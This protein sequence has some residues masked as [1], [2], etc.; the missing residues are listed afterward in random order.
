MTEA[1][2]WLWLSFVLG[3]GAPHCRRLLEVY[4]SAREVSEAVGKE[5]LSGLLTP[6]QCSRLSTDPAV[7]AP[8]EA[9]CARM[10]AQVLTLADDDYPSR[11]RDIEDAPPALF[12]TG[13]LSALNAGHTVGM[14]GSRRPSAYGVEA[15]A[16]IGKELA[17]AGV[18]LVSGLADGL[19]S[20]AHK[21]AVAAGAPTIGV[22]G[23]AID[24]T[25]PASNRR[26][27]AEME[28]TG[29][30]VSEFFPG[31]T[32]R[33]SNFLLRNRL[34]AALS[35]ALCVVEAREKSGTMNT[36]R[37]AERY[38][39]AVW[40]VPGGIF[41]EVC[42][43]TNRLLAEGRARMATGGGALLEALGLEGQ[44]AKPAAPAPKAPPLSPGAKAMLGRLSQTPRP[45][46]ALA[47]EAGLDAGSALAALLELEVAGKAQGCA[48]GLFRRK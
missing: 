1:C 22:L 9:R 32:A 18:C 8:M 29:A 47:A 41:S 42:A 14:I 39:R 28:Q 30:V 4:G 31:E 7:F 2:Y 26:L 27:R 24:Q 17:E 5:D 3:P 13:N 38:G 37:H 19:D 10:G 34:I 6:G 33:R 25:Y 35:D 43:G 21:A 36:V 45:L 46:E 12:A 40:A 48:G 16:G 44:R 11:L 20:E 23:T 15:A